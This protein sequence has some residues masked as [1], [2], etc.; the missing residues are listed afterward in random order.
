MNNTLLKSPEARLVAH[1]L[2]MFLAVWLAT[3]QAAGYKL[4][5]SVVI[6]A[7][8]AGARAALGLFSSTNPSVGRNI[9]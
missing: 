2:L 3:W 8:A 6:A 7:I 9:L 4:E 1:A 5:S